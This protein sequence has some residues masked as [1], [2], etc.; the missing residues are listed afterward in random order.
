MLVELE[1]HDIP[2]P[3]RNLATSVCQITE[4]SRVLAQNVK[5][6]VNEMKELSDYY[7]N[8][9]GSDSVYNFA[10]ILRVCES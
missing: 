7:F 9:S 1:D 8:F 2:E 6:D 4:F 10:E 5:R 3:I